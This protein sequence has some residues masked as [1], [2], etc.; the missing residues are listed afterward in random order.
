[1]NTEIIFRWGIFFGI[2]LILSFFTV[3]I[4]SFVIPIKQ[5]NKYGRDSLFWFFISLIASPY[6][7]ILSL[8]FLGE[9]DEK[10][11]ERIMEEEKLRSFNMKPIAD[12]IEYSESGLESWLKNNPTKTL[13]D[14]Y[15]R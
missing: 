12:K 5:A 3:L 7:A 9:T 13:S 15:N 10:R 6:V 4:L 14:Y 8:H 1:M 11:K 2:L